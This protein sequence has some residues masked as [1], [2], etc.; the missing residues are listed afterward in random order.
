MD[1]HIDRIGAFLV[2]FVTGG[3]YGVGLSCRQTPSLGADRAAVEAINEKLL[4]L[5]D[6]QAR[7]RGIP[8]DKAR[9]LWDRA[10]AEIQRGCEKA[11]SG[12]R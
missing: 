2:G 10:C 5:F 6:E 8:P 11:K 1:D 7:E 12:G 3:L 9:I 4:R